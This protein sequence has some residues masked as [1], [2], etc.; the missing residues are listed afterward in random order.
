GFGERS[1]YGLYAFGAILSYYLIASYLQLFMTDIGISAA[2]VGMIFIFAKIWDAVNDPLFGIIVDKAKF[3]KGKFIPWLRLASMAIPVSTILLFI[4]PSGA[5]AQMKII[6]STVAYILW[7]TAYTM[8]DVPMNAIVLS[9]TKKQNERQKLYVT[10]SFFVYLGAL[11]IAIAVP[12]LYPSIGWGP[13]GIIIGLTCLLGMLPLPF[14]AKERYHAVEQK[15]ANVKEI[16]TALIKNKY[17]LIFTAASIIGSL[18]NFQISIN[19]YFAIHNLGNE[20]WLTPLALVSAVPVLFVAPIVP[21]LCTKFEKFN[22]YIITRII[23]LVVDAAIFLLGYEN[24]GSFFALLI[25]KNI[26][27]AVFS[28]SAIMF[29]ADCVEYGHFTSGKRAEGVSFSLKAFTNKIIIALT[30]SIAMF[31]LAA[32]GFVEGSGAVQS[33]ETVKG[34][35]YLYSIGPMIGSVISTLILICT[36]RLRDKDVDIMTKANNG[37][38]THNEAKILL[39]GKY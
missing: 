10:A 23:S 21:K 2:A 30:G 39:S 38:I 34:I 28:L 25:V 22:V 16:L 20:S 26:F 19:G 18:T 24:I 8:Y 4:I 15:E 11:V 3:K 29:I 17:L 33:P 7:D 12:M 35:W 14:K 1:T 37:E 31:L 5:S 32:L 27:T 13:T 6:W 36:Y 9:M